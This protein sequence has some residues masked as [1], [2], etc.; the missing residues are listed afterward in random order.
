MNDYIKNMNDY[1]NFPP[2]A[3]EIIRKQNA[4]ILEK[5]AII[6]EFMARIAELESRLNMNSTNSSKPPSSDG[7]AKPAV[8]S[9][10]EKSGKKPGGQKGHKGH[11]LKIEREPDDVVV[12]QPIECPGCGCGLSKE[13]TF[14]ADTR[15]VYDV[16][17]E[18]KLTEY[19]IHKVICPCCGATVAG[20][21]PEE[22]KG[23]LNYGNKIRAL[24]VVLTQYA[25][26]GIDK[27]HKILRDL[28]EVSISA[29]T[30]KNITQQFASKT[31]DTI[32]EIKKKL[33]E[34]PRLNVDET[35]SRIN[36]RTQWFHVASNAKYTLVTSHMKRGKEGSEAGS[37]LPKYGGVL[38]HDCW[39]PY[40]GFDKC[41]HALCCAHLLRE[42]NAL[43]ERG[44][45][46]AK[47]MKTLLLEMKDVVE[48]YKGAD[49]TKL[50]GYYRDK[51]KTSYD[52]VLAKAKEEI[53][54]SPTRKKSKAE[55]ILARLEEYRAEI[56]RFTENFEV[57]FDNNQAERDLR[58]VKVKQKVSGCFRTE[59]GADDYAK[60]T[61]IIGTV[62]KFGQSVY[63]AVRGLFEGNKPNFCPATE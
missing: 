59:D 23:T 61:S 27:T 37:V 29:G 3:Q 18:V 19:D 40:F 17:I 22:C 9:L 2:E 21:L 44:Q 26:V 12:V 47:D 5:D 54:P 7:L 28:L 25:C 58:N 15:Y 38:V 55:N 35:G 20:T 1:T 24:A 42:L 8:T 10:R 34:S 13:A 53:T 51:F 6:A 33:L 46:W 57:P 45:T 32:A 52:A 11:G 60:T 50:S 41:E 62:V 14:H 39:K 56:T 36:G 31:D 49:K 30:I 16:Q 48:R 43:I 63:G 4:V